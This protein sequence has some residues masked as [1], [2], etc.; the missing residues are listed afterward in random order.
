[1][2]E[3]RQR[4]CGA[5][6]A[7]KVT[8]F[9]GYDREKEYDSLAPG[10]DYVK[11]TGL[12]ATTKKR[13]RLS[14]DPSFVTRAYLPYGADVRSSEQCPGPIVPSLYDPR[15]A[16]QPSSCDFVVEPLVQPVGVLPAP[17]KNVSAALIAV[18]TAGT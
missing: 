6:R 15:V 11:P 2:R 17:A 5:K 7:K 12:H 18:V 13:A 10:R 9:H 1:M 16:A 4:R 14:P 8:P 3:K